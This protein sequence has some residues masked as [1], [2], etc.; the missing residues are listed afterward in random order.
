MFFLPFEAEKKQIL[1]RCASQ[2][3]RHQVSRHE[4]HHAIPHLYKGS[5][6]SGYILFENPS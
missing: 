6:N 5:H 3:D 2:N 1:R 4:N